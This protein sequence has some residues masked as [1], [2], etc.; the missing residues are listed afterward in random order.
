MKKALTS[1]FIIF[2]LFVF[3][4]NNISINGSGAAAA[5]S[6]LL[7]LDASP[8]NNKGL[9]PPRLTSSEIN[10]IANPVNGLLVY[11]SSTKRLNIW[12]GTQSWFDFYSTQISN[13]QPSGTNLGPGVAI[14][15]TN[16]SPHHSAILDVQGNTGGLALPIV[17]STGSVPSPVE[18]LIVIS[19]IGYPKLEYYDGSSWRTLCG[20]T[21]STITGTTSN[22]VNVAIADAAGGTYTANPSSILD[23]SN[24]GAALKGLKLPKLTTT[25]RNNIR[26]P[27]EGLIIYNSTTKCINYYIGSNSWEELTS[28]AALSI[29]ALPASNITNTSFDANWSSSAAANGYDI[30]V[31]TDAALTN[32]VNSYNGWPASPFNFNTSVSCGTTYYYRVRATNICNTGAWSNVVSFTTTGSV[33]ATPTPSTITQTYTDITWSWNFVPGASGYYFNYTND[34]STASYLGNTNSV[35]SGGYP[36]SYFETLYVWAEDCGVSAPLTMTASTLPP[37]NGTVTAIAASGVGTNSFVANWTSSNPSSTY[38]LSVSTFS[39]FAILYPGYTNNYTGTS[40]SYTVSG[41]PECQPFYYRVYSTNN[42]GS[43]SPMSNTVTVNLFIPPPATVTANPATGVSSNTFVASWNTT[44]SYSEYLLDV[45]T[46]PSFSSFL[47]GYNGL[48]VSTATSSV[49]NGI[50]CTTLYYRVRAVDFCVGLGAYSNTVSVVMPVSPAPSSPSSPSTLSSAN[51]ITFNWSAAS[52]ANGYYVNTINDVS[53]ALNIGNT[54][55]HNL[56]GLPCGS[57]YTLYVWAYGVAGCPPSSPLPI[58]GSTGACP[59]GGGICGGQEFLTYNIDAGVMLLSGS[60]SQT[61]N[62]I[63]EKFCYM[64]IPAN[65][66]SYGGIYTGLE[67]LQYSAGVVC[68]PCGASGVQ[69]VCPSGY[70]VPSDYEFSRFEH[71]VE[72]TIAPTGTTTLQMFQEMGSAA[73]GFSILQGTYAPWVNDYRGAGPTP[74]YTVSAAYKLAGI[75]PWSGSDAIGFN[76]VPL[77]STGSLLLWTSTWG[78]ATPLACSVNSAITGGNCVNTY[79][80]VTLSPDIPLYNTAAYQAPPGQIMYQY[81]RQFYSNQNLVRSVNLD[82]SQ[83]Q[84]RCLKN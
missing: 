68:D 8:N 29:T 18:G 41:L 20:L 44:S 13:T 76:A 56:T 42:C 35:F 70:H 34:F 49:V 6:A 9:L 22:S 47:P 57:T 28:S 58:V 15:Q 51:S 64:D 82:Q 55:S 39:N 80:N 43:N 67:A 7:D 81:I 77:P 63:I 79:P 16:V 38:Y 11:N 1:I 48:S 74:N 21:A 5:S 72:T 54:T 4:Q 3:S 52:G 83:G 25:E 61:N 24:N 75:T 50:G 31:Y 27:A 17:F 65:C 26:S 60:D 30:E 71:C 37:A 14:G 23:I 12:L 32:L 69:G 40:T 78:G 36:C 45:S 73:G 19:A 10:N 84:V 53:S 46:S 59:P 33:P 62:G 66:A 2:N